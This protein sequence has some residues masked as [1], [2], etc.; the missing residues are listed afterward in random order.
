MASLANVSPGSSY[1]GL[2]KTENNTPIGTTPQRVTDGDG[3]LSPL[4]VSTID[5][6]NRGGGNILTNV[7]FGENALRDKVSG[8]SNVAI[9]YNTMVSN[10]IG[11]GNV[12]VGRAPLALMCNGSFNTAIGY[13]AMVTGGSSTNGNVVIGNRTMQL[14]NATHSISNN[15]AIGGQDT[16]RSNTGSNNIILGNGGLSSNTTASQNVGLGTSVFGGS[17]VSCQVAIG[18][19]SMRFNSTGGGNTALGYYS[20]C[21]TSSGCG[22]TGMGSNVMTNNTS[23]CFN[24]AAGFFAGCGN[25]SGSNNSILGSMATSGNFSSSVVLGACAAATANNQFVVGATG[26]FNAGAIT[27]ESVSPTHTWQVNI[28]GQNYKI[29]L[30]PV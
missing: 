2:L 13:E 5:V 15:I 11:N 4:L 12:A 3:N 14:S 24:T 29:P 7:A 16:M 30:I 18:H 1:P 10:Q 25:V 6:N 26:A 22:N 19:S 27:V 23:G 9:G 17:S 28:N 21:A 20:M 8:N